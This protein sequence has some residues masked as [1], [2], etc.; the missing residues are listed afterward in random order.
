MGAQA[1]TASTAEPQ[2]QEVGKPVQG[3]APRLLGNSVQPATRIASKASNVS[4]ATMTSTS[5]AASKGSTASKNSK[6]FLSDLVSTVSDP[7]IRRSVAQA[8]SGFKNPHAE[9]EAPSAS[10]KKQPIVSP[11]TL[12]RF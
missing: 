4:K 12:G 8:H 5:S 9:K 10:K 11:S 1:S 3:D 7:A 2:V 6:S